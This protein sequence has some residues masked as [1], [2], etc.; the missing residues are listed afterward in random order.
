MTAATRPRRMPSRRALIC[1][2][3]AALGAPTTQAQATDGYDG[4]ALY[5]ANCSSCHGIYGEGDGIVTPTLAVVLQDLRYLSQRNGGLFPRDFV[6]E[7]VDGRAMRA[8]HGPEG[9]PM[10]GAE[11][12]RAEGYGD[13]SE[14]R[15]DAKIQ[16]LVGF[17]ESIQIAAPEPAPAQ[18]AQ[19]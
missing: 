17:L 10:W 8:A 16:A 5:A 13:G 6:T 3:L 14:A 15:V 18:D 12:S 19:Q 2:L 7:I 9:M 11:F 1:L 4:S